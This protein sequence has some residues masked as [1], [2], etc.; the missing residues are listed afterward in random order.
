MTNPS[1]EQDTLEQLLKSPPETLMELANTVGAAV[2]LNTNPNYSLQDK[3]NIASI[4]LNHAYMAL[5][6]CG[7]V[8]STVVVSA[9][10]KGQAISRYQSGNSWSQLQ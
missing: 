1:V 4:M 3:I 8:I 6:Q 9:G 10:A 7:C 5:E 2:Q